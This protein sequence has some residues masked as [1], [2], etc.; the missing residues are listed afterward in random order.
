[1]VAILRS[2]F[3]NFAAAEVLQMPLR[4]GVS[5][6]TAP[7]TTAPTSTKKKIE[8]NHFTFVQESTVTGQAEISKSNSPVTPKKGKKTCVR[9]QSRFVVD[10]FSVCF[11]KNRKFWNVFGNL[12]LF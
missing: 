10:S 4:K 6:K 2:H 5:T 3:R 11:D 7:T 9:R 1:M 12:E 8:S